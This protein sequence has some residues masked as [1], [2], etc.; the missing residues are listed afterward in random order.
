MGFAMVGFGW[1]LL[2]VLSLAAPGLAESVLRQLEVASA[3]EGAHMLARAVDLA[4]VL[5]VGPAVEEYVFRGLLF[6]SW[7]ARWGVG[8]GVFGSSAVF[9][10]LH[11]NPLGAFLVGLVTCVLYV[12]TQSL[13]APIA[14]HVTINLLANLLSWLLEPASGA[15]DRASPLIAEIHSQWL[16][17]IACLAIGVVW[18]AIF[19]RRNWPDPSWHP[20][21][22]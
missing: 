9:A 21:G 17:G 15:A 8:A 12:R 3:P 5:M 6:R 13:A 18:A 1:L 2:F 10:L 22:S 20:P 19:V 14:A 4:F 16:L 7:T 11:V